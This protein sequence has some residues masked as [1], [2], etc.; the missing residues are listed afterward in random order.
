MHSV[1]L[2]CGGKIVSETYY[3]PYGR[4][5]LFSVTKSFVSLAIGCLTDEGKLS[6]DDCICDFFPEY[7]TEYDMIKQTTIRNMLMMRSPHDFTTYKADLNGNWVKS[8]FA[9]KPSHAPGAVFCYDTSA[10][11]TLCALAE[12]LSGKTLIDYLR[13]KFLNKIGFSKEA[14]CLKDPQGVSV[15][16]SGL[17]ARPSDILKT[18]EFV[19]R[20]GKAGGEQLISKNYLKL[21]RQSETDTRGSFADECQG[22]GMQFWMTRN[23]GQMMYG[24]GGQLAVMLPEKDTVFVTTADTM[25]CRGGVHSILESFWRNIYPHIDELREINEESIH[26]MP[27][28][29]GIK[30]GFFGKY[31]FSNNKLRI[32]SIEIIT[33]EDKGILRYTNNLGDGELRFGMCKNIKG[34]FPYYE[35]ECYTSGAWKDK[36]RLIIKSRLTGECVGSVT[37][38][39]FIGDNGKLTLSSRK[40][41][42]HEFSEWNGIVT[43]G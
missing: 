19:M 34:V 18:A 3:K 14:Y 13:E 22:Y 35:C 43:G 9:T 11:H 31:E 17:M 4:N 15:G 32:K 38:E 37:M 10:T 6:L 33:D 28:E 21:S 7:P 24:M 26:E 25:G 8:F 40:I 1:I 42:G 20:G 39:F 5:T 23:N 16:G 29:K 2:S 12:K 27:C 36:D 30:K 41:E